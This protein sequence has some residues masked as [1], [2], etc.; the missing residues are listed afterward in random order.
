MN[1]LFTTITEKEFCENF[2]FIIS[3]VQRGNS[4]Y[5]QT[6]DSKLLALIPVNDPIAQSLMQSSDIKD[7]V[8]EALKSFSET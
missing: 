1:P 8:E 7:E 6:K 2:E 5:V 3:L 4:F